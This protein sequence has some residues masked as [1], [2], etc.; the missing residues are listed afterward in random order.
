[1]VRHAN[2]AFPTDA[3]TT[4]QRPRN[5][6]VVQGQEGRCPRC[7]APL[8]VVMTAAGPRFRCACR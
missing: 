3:E 5:R 2:F 6:A 7:N 1:M 8:V 4:S